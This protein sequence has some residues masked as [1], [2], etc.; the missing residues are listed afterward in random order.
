VAVGLGLGLAGGGLGW[1]AGGLGGLGAD[2]DGGAL[3]TGPTVVSGAGALGTAGA[4]VADGVG[5]GVSVAGVADSATGAS[6]SPLPSL[7]THQTEAVPRVATTAAAI[8]TLVA[9]L[10]GRR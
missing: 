10:S 5:A 6:P 1:V 7:A 9:R 3:A 4:V 2:V 8:T